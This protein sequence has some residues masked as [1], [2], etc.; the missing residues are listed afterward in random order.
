MPVYQRPALEAICNP[1]TGLLRRP[2][3]CPDDAHVPTAQFQSAQ[4]GSFFCT[5]PHDLHNPADAGPIVPPKVRELPRQTMIS[6]RAD[7]IAMV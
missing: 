3:P 5:R 6:G 1:A 4:K 2:T 7:C